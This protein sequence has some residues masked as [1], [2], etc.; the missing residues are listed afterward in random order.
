[1][2]SVGS[3]EWEARKA[4]MVEEALAEAVRL[5]NFPDGPAK[6]FDS[7]DESVKGT[8]GMVKSARRFAADEGPPIL[9]LVGRFGSGKTHIAQ[10]IGRAYVEQGHSARYETAARMLTALRATQAPDS[11]DSLD[12]WLRWYEEQTVLILDDLGSKDAA[13]TAWARDVV[14]EIIDHR[15]ESRSRLVITTNLSR[16][17]MDTCMGP[18]IAS[19]LYEN[20]PKLKTVEMVTVTAGDYRA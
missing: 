9:I 13:E 3:D 20:N 19:R 4:E 10:A 17:Q 7:F 15:L 18:R 14:K 6:T 12:G 11:A 1:L 5:Q 16:P 8:A 2:T